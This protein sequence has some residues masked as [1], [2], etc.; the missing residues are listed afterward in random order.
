M[1]SLYLVVEVSALPQG[2]RGERDVLIH[3]SDQMPIYAIQVEA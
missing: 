2:N 3:N 1:G